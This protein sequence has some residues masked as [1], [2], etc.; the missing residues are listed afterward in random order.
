[1]AKHTI[2]FELTSVEL[3]KVDSKIHIKKDGKQFGTITISKG[4]LEWYPSKA[5]KPYK[6][7]WTTLDK[8]IKEYHG[9]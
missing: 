3:G 1:M 6:I 7:G 5:K 9:E 4:D 8:I 2:F